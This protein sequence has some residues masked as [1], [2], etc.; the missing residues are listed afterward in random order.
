[1]AGMRLQTTLHE[2]LQDPTFFQSPPAY[3][4][5]GRE[6]ILPAEKDIAMKFQKAS[7][8]VGVALAMSAGAKACGGSTGPVRATRSFTQIPGQLASIAVGGGTLTQPDEV[9]GINASHEIFH[10]NPND[11]P[12]PG[13]FEQIPGSLTQISVGAGYEPC[14]QAEV[15]GL[16]AAGDIYRFDYCANSFFQVTGTLAQI[17]VGDGEVWGLAAGGQIYQFNLKNGTRSQVPAVLAGI[18]TGGGQVWG[19][20]SSS[21]S[22]GWNAALVHLPSY[23]VAWSRSSSAEMVSGAL[24]PRA[25]STVSMRAAK[26]SSR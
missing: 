15:W 19:L 21:H 13:L 12:A 4:R 16:N 8:F 24:S 6:K 1:M 3:S 9:W 25:Q 22:S 26:D 17:T 7:L 10:F 11:L 14:H 18:A 23:Q 2:L 5:I 20:N